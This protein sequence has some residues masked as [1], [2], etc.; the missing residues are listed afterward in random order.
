[1]F[2][3]TDMRGAV[4]FFSGSSGRPKHLEAVEVLAHRLERLVV[5]EDASI[6]EGPLPAEHL[7][8]GRLPVARHAGYSQDLAAGDLQAHGIDRGAAR[9]VIGQETSQFE[10]GLAFAERLPAGALADHRVA[11]HH[12]RHRVRRQI[13]DEPAADMGAAPQHRHGVAIGHD[14]AELVADHHDREFLPLGHAAQQAQDLVGLVRR[15]H[16]GGLIED[17]EVLVEVEQLQDLEFLLLARGERRNRLVERHLERHPF[18]ERG[19]TRPFLLPVD[20]GRRV[21]PAD[22][23]VLGSGERG[24]QRE[25]LVDHADAERPRVLRIAHL[26]LA[27][28]HRDRAFVGLVEAHD[29]FHQRRLAGAV[30]AEQHVK[31]PGRNIDR[32]V[33]ERREGAEPLGHPRHGEPDGLLARSR[34]ERR[35][36][37]KRS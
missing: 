25:L 36:W 16:G 35:S 24:H 30:L 14:L 19:E 4:A 26:H 33:I 11:D 34:R 31:L 5:H 13:L 8:Q 3:A 37:A 1:M 23:E 2:S 28:V 12:A 29:A 22:D 18:H 7:D 21:G 9:I 20:H 17:Q 15:Q 27:A 32:D 6:P 10:H